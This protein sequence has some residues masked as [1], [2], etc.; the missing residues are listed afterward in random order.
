MLAERIHDRVQ[1]DYL[2]PDEV[3][4]LLKILPETVR[5]HIRDG[6]IPAAKFGLQW[7]IR[8][9]DLEARFGTVR[10]E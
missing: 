6:E 9:S 7:R 2:S 5:K 1:D 10:K 3:A 8:R 4:A